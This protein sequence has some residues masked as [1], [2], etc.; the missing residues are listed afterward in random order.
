MRERVQLEFQGK[1]TRDADAFAAKSLH[2]IKFQKMTEQTNDILS[3]FNV[4]F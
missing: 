1:E 2:E 4:F 3:F